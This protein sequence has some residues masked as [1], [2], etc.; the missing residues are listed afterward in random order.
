MPSEVRYVIFSKSELGTAIRQ[1]FA[2]TGRSLPIGQTRQIRL[3]VEVGV[4][5]SLEI[6][7]D[8]NDRVH[9]IFIDTDQIV[10]AL[11]L[12]CKDAE[13]PLPLHSTKVLQIVGSN[14]CLFICK[15]MPTIGVPGLKLLQT[16]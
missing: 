6:V 10:S 12:Y 14:V 16:A 15:N 7:E 1:Y 11:I 3:T 2:K 5:A 9:Q 13:V 8:R 4:T